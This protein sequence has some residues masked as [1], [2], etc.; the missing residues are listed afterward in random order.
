MSAA[1]TGSTSP[2]PTMRTGRRTN[3]RQSG[4]RVPL[5][6]RRSADNPIRR[7]PNCLLDH[8][9]DARHKDSWSAAGPFRSYL[10]YTAVLMTTTSYTAENFIEVLDLTKGDGHLRSKRR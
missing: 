7:M 1:S 2:P 10:T 5:G 3:R 6:R 4:R 9:D 8:H